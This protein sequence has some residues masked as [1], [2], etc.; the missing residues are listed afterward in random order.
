MP[1]W[2]RT[3]Q[4]G[5][6]AALVLQFTR[7]DLVDRYAGSLLGGLWTFIQPLVNMLVFILVFSRLMGARLPE[8]GGSYSYSIY[9]ISAMLGWTAFASTLT[10]T[11][12]VFL[13]KA[14]VITKVR[15][16][17]WSLPLSVVLSDTIVFAI[18]MMFFL[19]FLLMVGHAITIQ[20]LWVP[21]IFGVQQA[22]A[23]TLGLIAA[24]LSVFFRDVRESV[25]VVLQLWFWLT[26]IVYVYSIIPPPLQRWLRLNPIFPVVDA[27]HSTI[28]L[29]RAPAF[30]GL[31]ALCAVVLLLLILGRW[32]FG[33][34]EREIRDLI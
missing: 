13:D 17:L 6:T 8:I 21:I 10:R 27:Y 34:L 9:L 5:V 20:F 18:S 12:T 4:D 25:A 32:V 1:P 3:G 14:H 26:P 33:R 28:M 30:S 16:S 29:G 24:C 31:I 11:T 23:Y 22:F 19:A 15:V 7:Q 2:L